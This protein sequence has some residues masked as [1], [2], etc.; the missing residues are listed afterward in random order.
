M[1]GIFKRN[2]N[3][4]TKVT[5]VVEFEVEYEG[6]ITQDQIDYTD[7]FELDNFNHFKKLSLKKRG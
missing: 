5:V 3:K 7:V 1:L 4:S 6:H 2:Q